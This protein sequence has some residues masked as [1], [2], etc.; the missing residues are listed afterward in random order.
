VKLF[1][2]HC[3]G[4]D[5][6]MAAF[7]PFDE[8]VGSTISIPWFFYLIEHPNGYVLFDTGTHPDVAAD[9]RG[10]LGEVADLWTITMKPGEDA[11]SLLEAAGVA[12]T[13]IRH[14]IQSHL[15][16]DHAGSVS[17]FP[18][19]EVY[20]QRAELPFA[21]WPPVYQSGAYVRDDFDHAINWR[22]VEGE[23]DLFGDGRIVMFPTPGHT[24]GHQSLLLGL[25]SG[26]VILL[27][28][29]TYLIA[30]MRQRR[31]PAVLW[32]PDAMV[33]S[34]HYIEKLEERHNAHLIATHELDYKETVKLAPQEWYD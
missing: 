21:F 19:A 9:P 4:E 11:V 15:H 13:D 18:R 16:Y 5:A 20:V 2:F 7:D 30:K 33:A 3:G 28:D 25:D 10:R 17:F 31:L 23:L 14:V 22:E 24:A 12:A 26:P 34:W 32:S 29:A 6:D 1:A 27:S 8:R